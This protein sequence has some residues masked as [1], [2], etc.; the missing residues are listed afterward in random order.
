MVDISEKSLEQTIEATL[1]AGGPDA[2][3]GGEGLAV[4]SLDRYENAPG[5]YRRRR[6]EDYNKELCLDPGMAIDF[7]LATQPKV[8]ERLKQ[9]HGSEVKERFLKRLSSEIERRGTLDVLRNGIKD[10][11]CSFKLA[12]FRPASGLNED[13]Q[14][15]A[16]SDSFHGCPPA[17]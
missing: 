4:E 10:S 13:L 14:A 5:G 12:Y 1:L 15:I 9:H 6:P 8:W 2:Y 16:R 7:I 3:P 17:S 11:G